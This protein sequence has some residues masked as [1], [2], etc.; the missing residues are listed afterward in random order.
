MDFEWDLVKE[1]AN[2]QKHGISFLDAMAVFDDPHRLEE[3]TTRPEHG[4]DRRKAIGRMGLV[5]VTVIFTDR[6]GRR[7]L[8]SARRARRDERARYDQGA[9]TS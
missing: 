7:R 6:Q 1:A 2:R 9:A 4:E 8:I 5:L 3:D